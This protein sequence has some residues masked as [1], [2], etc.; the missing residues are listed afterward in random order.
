M[1]R[2][3]VE[4]STGELRPLCPLLNHACR[5]DLKG[6]IRAK[7][8]LIV[9]LADLLTSETQIKSVRILG[10]PIVSSWYY[11]FR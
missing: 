6:E 1:W 10:Q 4:P 3:S 7:F 8:A 2:L 5:G 11:S 9:T